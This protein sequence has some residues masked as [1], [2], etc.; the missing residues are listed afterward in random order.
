[1]TIAILREP[2]GLHEDLTGVVG[3]G[4]VR[5]L[6]NIA[7]DLLVRQDDTGAYVPRLAQE[8]ISAERGTWR[9]FPD[10][11]METVWKLRAGITWHDGTPFTAEDL[12][13]SLAVYKDPQ[14]PSSVGR[15]LAL[16]EAASAPDPLTLSI[17]WSGT[18]VRADEAPGLIPMPRHLLEEKYRSDKLNFTA[19]PWFTTEFVGLGPYRLVGWERGVSMEFSRFDDY[20]AGRAHIDTVVARFLGDQNAMLAGLL[21]RAVDVVLPEGVDLSAAL[22]LRRRWAGTGNRVLFELGNLRHLEIQHRPEYEEPSFSTTS[23]TARQALSQTIDRQTL[24]DAIGDGSLLPA[25]SW[26][27]P[28]QDLRGQVEAS[29]PQFPYDPARAQQLFAEAG[30]IRGEDGTLVHRQS[31]E[32]FEML[33][34]GAQ[35]GSVEREQNIIADAWKA[36]GVQPRLYL[37]PAALAADREHRSKLPGMGLNGAGFDRLT[38]DYFKSRSIPSDANRWVGSNRGGYTNPRVDAI[39]DRLES[40]IDPRERIVA[41]RELLQEQLGDLALIPLYWGASPV[42]ALDDVSGIRDNSATNSTWN[43]AAWD[44]RDKR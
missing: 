11:S 36:A 35:M 3:G 9:V 31:G 32:R 2:A 28:N 41:H 22:E 30:W 21:A 23:R 26:F 40:T 1:M 16:M 5:Q 15:P 44:K 20:Y 12:L 14:I 13:F 19:G 25:D 43:V 8:R 33:I 18:Y 10:G 4:G 6:Y 37:I 29:I 34:Y 7:Q 24:A 38:T 17:R 39:L 27:R 42:L